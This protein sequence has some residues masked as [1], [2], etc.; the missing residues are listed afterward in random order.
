[1]VFGVFAERHKC[2]KE[3]E[4]R[5]LEQ[6]SKPREI[7]KERKTTINNAIKRL[8]NDENGAWNQTSLSM[9]S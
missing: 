1:M 3:K 4:K 7:R 8:D 6:Q 9:N 2:E 5:Q